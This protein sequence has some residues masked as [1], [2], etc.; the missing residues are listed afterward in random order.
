MWTPRFYTSRAGRAARTGAPSRADAVFDCIP[1]IAHPRPALRPAAALDSGA[2]AP[3][4]VALAMG[5]NSGRLFEFHHI[6]IENKLLIQTKFFQNLHDF[7][8]DRLIL[9]FRIRCRSASHCRADH[10]SS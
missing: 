7:P 4:S 5:A 6:L 2:A 9:S 1:T 8:G 10:V 3:A